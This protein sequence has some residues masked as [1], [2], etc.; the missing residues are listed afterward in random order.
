M[1]GKS[2]APPPPDLPI[3]Y[4]IMNGPMRDDF[5]IKT[6]KSIEELEDFK[7]KC[8][9]EC[10][11]KHKFYTYEPKETPLLVTNEQYFVYAK[12][13][14][15]Q[16]KYN[17]IYQKIFADFLVKAT[18][19]LEFVVDQQ[20]Q[21]TSAVGLVKV[22]LNDLKK[23]FSDHEKL[24]SY[25]FKIVALDNYARRVSVYTQFP[26][27]P[28][29]IV[30]SNLK[31]SAKIVDLTTGYCKPTIFDDVFSIYL[32]TNT[33]MMKIVSNYLKPMKE[34]KQLDLSQINQIYKSIASVIPITNKSSGIVLRNSIIRYFFDE[35]YQDIFVFDPNCDDVLMKKISVTQFATPRQLQIPSS[36]MTEQYMDTPFTV[37]ARKQLSEATSHLQSLPFFVSGN[38][39]VYSVHCTLAA[40]DKFVKA[41]NMEQKYG[42]FTDMFEDQKNGSTLS[43]DDC[44]AIFWP[45]FCSQQPSGIS[46]LVKMISNCKDL[47]LSSPLEFAKLMLASVIDYSQGVDTKEMV[48]EFAAFDDQNSDPLSH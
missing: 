41:A 3:R 6:K 19:V 9:E 43:F 14:D 25:K 42:P 15:L 13:K 5:A 47:R 45:L 39:I 35:L 12:L 2:S 22:L 17:R 46:L 44:F 16:D 20:K 36:L 38:D 21:G 1:F 33:E 10:V 37:L 29:D 34:A 18:L 7:K 40:I 31:E 23:T 32:R 24:R 26:A 48:E 27:I 30:L 11:A 4:I 28:L 8:F